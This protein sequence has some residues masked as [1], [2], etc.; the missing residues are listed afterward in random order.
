MVLL[1]TRLILPPRIGLWQPT[2]DAMPPED[3]MEQSL[4]GDDRPVVEHDGRAY[5]LLDLLRSLTADE[6]Q[7]IVSAAPHSGQ[8][9]WDEAVRRWPALTAE[10]VAG[11]EPF[12]L[13]YD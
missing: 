9:L 10:I 7:E 5:F 3:D 4:P 12:P 1:L 2:G 13:R 6:L 11:A 8:E